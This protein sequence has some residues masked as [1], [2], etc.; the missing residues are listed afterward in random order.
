[1]S[2]HS[3][4]LFVFTGTSGSGRKTAAHRA[5]KENEIVHIPSC[6]DRPP[7]SKEHPDSDY[8]YVST[9]Q[10]ELML[11]NQFFAESVQ[12]DHYHY[13]IGRRSLEASLNAGKSVYLIVNR[14]GTEKL[15]EQ[16]GEQ[17]VRIFIYVDKNTIL[18][19]L[20]AKGT[21]YEII[22]RYLSHYS[23]EVTYRKSCEHVIENVDIE[24][25]IKKIREIVLSYG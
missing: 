22:D 8:R 18:Q 13:G 15:R 12:I 6:T 20:E 1:M 19:R 21:S 7:R 2:S 23:E 10:F 16:Y 4:Y 5:L 14:E 3:P 25:T 9:A 24:Q 17:V 11:L